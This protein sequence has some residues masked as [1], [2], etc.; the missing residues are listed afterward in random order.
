MTL[1]F[2][3]VNV[4]TEQIDRAAIDRQYQ[5]AQREGRIQNPREDVLMF[6]T[7]VPG[8]IHFNSTRII[9]LDP[10]DPMAVSRAEALGR[11]PVSYTHLIHSA[12]TDAACCLLSN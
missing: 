5:Q 4:D 2:R 6:N 8:M 11:E 10:T 3:M 12:S 9:K 7:L 1:C